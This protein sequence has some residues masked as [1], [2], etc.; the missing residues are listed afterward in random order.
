MSVEHGSWITEG[1][2]N[3]AAPNSAASNNARSTSQC[4]PITTKIRQ[5]ILDAGGTDQIK[6]NTTTQKLS[7]N[8]MNWYI[9]NSPY[10]TF[11]L[12][13]NRAT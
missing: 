11:N 2:S 4:L 9:Q 13:R 5:Q 12:T 6:K 3:N 1:A 10:I 8:R 7:K